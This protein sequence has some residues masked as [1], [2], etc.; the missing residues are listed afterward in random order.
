MGHILIIVVSRPARSG[1]RKL[2]GAEYHRRIDHVTGA[3]TTHPLLER[4]D[5]KARAMLPCNTAQEIPPQESPMSSS[6]DD[7]IKCWTAQLKTPLVLD[8]VLEKTTVANASR[9]FDLL[10]SLACG[11][12]GASKIEIQH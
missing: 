8:I 4:I 1:R 2:Q 6:M 5:H 7:E 3:S 11:I 12:Q 10:L 9:A